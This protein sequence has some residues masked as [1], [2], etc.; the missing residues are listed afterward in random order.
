M[1]WDRCAVVVAATNKYKHK[2][3]TK[4]LN[5]IFV[6]SNFL[7]KYLRTIIGLFFFFIFLYLSTISSKLAYTSVTVPRSD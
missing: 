5:R 2:L 4:T 7:Y 3:T 1:G 6:G